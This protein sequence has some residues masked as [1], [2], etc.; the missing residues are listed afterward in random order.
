MLVNKFLGDDTA[1]GSGWCSGW[2]CGLASAGSRVRFPP[3]VWSVHVLSVISTFFFQ[4]ENMHIR[5]SVCMCP[6]R[7]GHLGYKLQSSFEPQYTQAV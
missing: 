6:V 2:D 1:Q 4:S 7:N 3:R 5:L